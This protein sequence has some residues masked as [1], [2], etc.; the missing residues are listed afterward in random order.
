MLVYLRVLLTWKNIFNPRYVWDN[1][2]QSLVMRNYHAIHDLRGMR[3]EELE[4]SDQEI[5]SGMCAY[6]VITC[7]YISIIYWPTWHALV[8]MNYRSSILGKAH[9][10]LSI[11]HVQTVRC[12][13]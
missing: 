12:Q 11:A 13:Q 7:M 9:T 5:H 2:H 4:I 10:R 1:W 6:H 3:H 8:Y